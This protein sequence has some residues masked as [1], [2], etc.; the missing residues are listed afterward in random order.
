MNLSEL[1]LRR[2]VLAMVCSIIILIFGGIGFKFLG[3]RE[4]PAIDPAVINVR[5]N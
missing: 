3:V 4:Y 1:S 5:T 2:P